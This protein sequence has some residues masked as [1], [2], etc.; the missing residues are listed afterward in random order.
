MSRGPNLIDCALLNAVDRERPRGMHYLWNGI[1]ELTSNSARAC[2]LPSGST[3]VMRSGVKSSSCF[4]KTGVGMLFVSL[5]SR[6]SARHAF[7]DFVVEGN[8]CIPQR[9]PHIHH[10]GCG[11]EGIKRLLGTH[12]KFVDREIAK[13]A[14][15]GSLMI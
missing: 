13:T 11:H 1:F 8:L 3:A 9:V 10:A 4:G 12:L 2:H 7:S 5:W 15:I 6:C 14:G